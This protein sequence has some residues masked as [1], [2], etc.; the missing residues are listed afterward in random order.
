MQNLPAP[1][2]K[3]LLNGEH[4]QCNCRI[5]I[6]KVV[7]VCVYRIKAYTW[8]FMFRE[9]EFGVE[10]RERMRR[11]SGQCFSFTPMCPTSETFDLQEHL[12]GSLI[13][14][15]TFDILPRVILV[16]I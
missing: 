6:N 15:R 5:Q 16:A 11:H 10:G 7:K 12:F 14:G 9:P 8:R 3:I 1:C 2:P 13:K 4:I